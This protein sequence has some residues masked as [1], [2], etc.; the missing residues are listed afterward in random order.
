MEGRFA[1]ISHASVP[2]SKKLPPVKE[3]KPGGE[4]ALLKSYL[5]V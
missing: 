4:C 3:E 2:L 1:R 5:P